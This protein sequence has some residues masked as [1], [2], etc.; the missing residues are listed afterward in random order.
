MGRIDPIDQGSNEA[1]QCQGEFH[2]PFY[3][4]IFHFTAS[5]RY[6]KNPAPAFGTLGLQSGG[7]IKYSI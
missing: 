4:Q 6:S 7:R 3:F 5:C 2:L 1:S